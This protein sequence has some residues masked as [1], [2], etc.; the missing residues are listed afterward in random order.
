[1]THLPKINVSSAGAFWALVRRDVHLAWAQGG[2][3]TLTIGFFLIAVSLFPFGVGPEPQVLARIAPGVLWVI[4]LLACVISLDRLYQADFEDGSLD[5]LV[6]SPV[7]FLG[8]VCAKVLAHWLSTT[9]PLAV[10]APFLGVM[11]NLNAD[12]FVVL[13]VSLLIG[14]PALSL[15][16]SVGAALTVAVRRGGVLMSLIV[17]PLYVP[18]LIFGVGAVDAAVNLVDPLPHLA[19]LGA[20]SLMAIVAG[21]WASVMALKLAME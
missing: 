14:T 10:L 16:G 17:L 20:V 3:S 7:G 15:I 9:L 12:G 21:I 8:V 2:A 4:A 18:T 13:I 11:M 6:L 1:M 19:L 5:D